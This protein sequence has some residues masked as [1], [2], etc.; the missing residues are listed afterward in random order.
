MWLKTFRVDVVAFLSLS[1]C[2]VVSWFL[3]MLFGEC[4]YMLGFLN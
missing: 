2:G 1:V 4:A 3:T